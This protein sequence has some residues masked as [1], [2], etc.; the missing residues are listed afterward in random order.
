[1][2]TE[3]KSLLSSN[4]KLSATISGGGIGFFSKLLVHGG[5]SALLVR[6]HIPYGTSTLHTAA[7][8]WQHGQGAVSQRTAENVTINLEQSSHWLDP[9]ERVNH[10]SLCCTATMKS[11]RERQGREHRAWISLR[12]DKKPNKSLKISLSHYLTR[13]EQEDLLSELLLKLLAEYV[14]VSSEGNALVEAKKQDS[15]IVEHK[16]LE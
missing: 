5:G 9:N 12:G 3:I 2:L 14:G 4:H 16:S 1:V 8:P 10:V 15:N 13:E 6:G 7:A 11:E